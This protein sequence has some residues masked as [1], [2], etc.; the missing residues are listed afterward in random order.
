MTF[1]VKEIN[2]DEKFRDSLFFIQ[3]TIESLENEINLKMEREQLSEKEAYESLYKV[4]S[5]V[6]SKILLRL[7]KDKGFEF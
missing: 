1:L 4:V 5:K 6:D 2:K 3:N 7:A